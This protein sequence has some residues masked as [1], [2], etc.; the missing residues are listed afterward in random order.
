MT[1]KM[2]I[3]KSIEEFHEVVEIACSKSFRTQRASKKAMSNKAVPCWTG[4]LTIMRKRLNTLRCR[5]KRMRNSEEL[6]EQRRSQYL[7]GKARYAATIKK[8][9]TTSWKEYCNM[10][11]STNPWNEVYKLDAG[12]RNNNTQITTLQK[13]DGSLTADLRETSKHMLEHFTQKDK[14]NDDTDY[15]KQARTQSHEPVDMANDKDFTIEE[16][17]NAVESMGNK[18]APGEEGITGKIYRS[19][20][21]IFPSYITALYSGCLR[22]GILPMRWKRVKLITIRKPGKEKSKDI[23][24]FCPICLLNIGEKVLEEVLINR[25]NHH[26]F[27]HDLK[28]NSQNGSTPQRG[29]TDV[30]MAMKNFT[31]KGLVAQ[32]V[33]VLVSLDVKGAFDA[34]WWPSILNGLKACG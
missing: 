15:H 26:V 1:H 31:E 12:K 2:E 4:E 32:E 28:N 9:K 17:R 13:P 14:E 3:E 19:T 23:S 5:Y 10:M 30:A 20:F 25:I 7:E 21:E 16:I 6:I 18:K 33:T 27:S 24:I 8:E 34:A 11:S 22:R 29:T